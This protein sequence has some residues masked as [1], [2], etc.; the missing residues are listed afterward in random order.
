MTDPHIPPPPPPPGGRC[1]VM[2]NSGLATHFGANLRHHRR[3]ARLSQKELAARASL[4]RT[5]IGLLERGERIPRL[6]TLLSLARALSVSAADLMRGLDEV[7]PASPPGVI[8]LS[9]RPDGAALAHE[10]VAPSQ[11][12][13]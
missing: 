9:A 1:V 5:T 2:A 10:P 13:P 8:A 6:D 12:D 3:R 7:W 4:D 11:V